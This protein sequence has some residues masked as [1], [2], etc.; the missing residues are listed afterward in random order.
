MNCIAC[1]G[2][3]GEGDGPGAAALQFPP[4]RLGD[5]V[6]FHNDGTIFL[7]ISEGIPLDGETQNMLGFKE[8]LT[9][10]ERWHLVNFLR[11]TFKVGDFVPV[12]PEDLAQSDAER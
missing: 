10:D 8:I 6:P 9:V 5:H 7:W 2:R 11:A 3:T 12:L 4:P 1:H